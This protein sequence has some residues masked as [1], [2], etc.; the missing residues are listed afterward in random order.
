MKVLIADDH[1]I[2]CAG[3]ER[4]IAEV[5]RSKPYKVHHLRNVE[6]M[7][8]LINEVLTLAPEFVR[9]VSRSVPRATA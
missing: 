2:V 6:Q 8:L 3:L 5:P 9:S 4:M 7:L 1:D